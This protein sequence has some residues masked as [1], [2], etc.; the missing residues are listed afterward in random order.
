MASTHLPLSDPTEFQSHFPLN[1][2]PNHEGLQSAT[3][4][5]SPPCVHGHVSH[6]EWG[7]QHVVLLTQ[8]LLIV[9]SSNHISLLTPTHQGLQSTVLLPSTTLCSWPCFPS[10][11]GWAICG[12]THPTPSNRTEF[13][14]HF[15]PNPYP[16]GLQSTILL[17]S[18]TLCSWP[19]FPSRVGWVILDSWHAQ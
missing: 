10:R 19:W 9:Q 1:P 18:T 13:Q 5:L 4:S 8:P 14:S 12:I 2:Y 7:E 11:V 16:P 17:P 6:P 15:P 3:L